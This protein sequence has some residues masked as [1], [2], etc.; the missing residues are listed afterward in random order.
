MARQGRNND[1][2]TLSCV[3]ILKGVV[4]DMTDTDNGMT[5]D[6]PRGSGKG[7][8]PSPSEEA[9]VDDLHRELKALYQSYGEDAEMPSEIRRLAA[10][11][12]AKL[13]EQ[14]GFKAPDD[15]N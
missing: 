8:A 2:M 7:R 9:K 11:L 14:S 15:K 12:S 1:P 10:E 6:Y 13:S 3:V 5:G 4:R